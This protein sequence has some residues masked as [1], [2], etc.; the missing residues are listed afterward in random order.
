MRAIAP[1]APPDGAGS[2]SAS[3]STV[4]L[5]PADLLVRQYNRSWVIHGTRTIYDNPWVKLDLAD[6]EPPGVKRFEHDA[7][8]LSQAAVAA[9]VDDADRVLMLWR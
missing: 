5:T 4:S 3:P 9:I 7:V 1:W 2:P 6:V 8:R